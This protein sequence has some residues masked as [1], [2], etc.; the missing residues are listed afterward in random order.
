MET[1]IQTFISM[2]QWDTAKFLI[3]SGNV[4]APL[5]YYSHFFALIPSFAIGLIILL[6]DKKSLVN[7]IL[8]LIT[9]LFSVW[10]LFDLVLWATEKPEFTMFFWAVLVLIEPLIYALCVYF[11]DVFINKEDISFKKKLGIFLPLLPIIILLPTNLVL[12]G[13]DL[14]NCDRAAT[15]GP[16]ST[17]YVYA[18]E[19]VYVFWIFFF[20]FRKYFKTDK[21]TKR[22]V[23]LMTT[24]IILF[25][26][27]FSLGNIIES[28]TSNWTIGQYGLF[29][30]PV[31]V[32][33]L[34][35][36][37]IKFK[38]FN[39]KV[40]TTQ[41]LVFVLAFLVF[42]ILF[43]RYIQDVRLIVIATLLFVIVL[44]NVLIKSVKREIKQK[45][46]LAK[47]DADLENVIQQRESLM[48]LINH[49]VKGS[50]THS[51]YIFAGLLDGQFGEI[52]PEVKKIAQAGLDSDTM[53]IRTIDLILNAANLQSGTIKYEMLPVDLREI[54]LK[55]IEDKKNSIEQKGLKLAMS[56]PD[57]KVEIKGD[58]FWLKEVFN[59]LIEN[60]LRYTEQGTISIGLAKKDGKI[61]FTIKDTGVGITPEDKKNLFTEGGRG[62]ESTKFNVDSTGYGLY[63]VKL[64]VEAHKG[65]VWAESEGTGKGSEFYVEFDAI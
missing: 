56:M 28:F 47:L 63:S 61:I 52:S 8:F 24:G 58:I 2:C 5:I 31:F 34:A 51:K 19:I 21:E 12:N 11:I 38:T 60:S 49:K 13:F 46:E 6:R 35:Y 17:Y 54:I 43:I 42:A 64:I 37:I 40:L 15:Q 14:T 26:L 62:K 36:M 45:E 10:V 57:E 22:Q 1:S 55:T 30:M 65:R 29:G 9:V 44:G 53:G 59:N 48:H 3:F 7:Q 39:I 16:V 32:G 50:F 41:V 4:F 27:S 33:F 23:L 20:A 25:L 18:I